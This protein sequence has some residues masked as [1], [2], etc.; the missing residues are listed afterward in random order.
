LPLQ[1]RRGKKRK[2]KWDLEIKPTRYK[3][4]FE[5]IGKAMMRNTDYS[6]NFLK[7]KKINPERVKI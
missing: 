6:V 5:E 7:L 3:K 1:K 4:F 2:K